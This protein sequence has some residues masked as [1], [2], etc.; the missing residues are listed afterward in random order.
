MNRQRYTE[1][2]L[3][4]KRKK[5]LKTKHRRQKTSIFVKSDRPCT[6]VETEFAEKWINGHYAVGQK[7]RGIN[8]KHVVLMV[9]MKNRTSYLKI[10]DYVK[11]IFTEHNQEAD[12]LANLG[13]EGQR[14]IVVDRR[15]TDDSGWQCEA[16]GTA[17]PKSTKEAA[18]E[19]L[20]KALPGTSGSP[21]AKARYCWP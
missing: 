9:E 10:D 13:A 8:S 2:K 18:V 16:S 4:R 14:H 20:S 17:A 15:N 6:Y 11:Q 3:G 12:D 19:S 1:K 7:Y 21:S 5:E